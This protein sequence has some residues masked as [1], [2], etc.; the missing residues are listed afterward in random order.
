ML[1]RAACLAP[2][3]AFAPVDFPGRFRTSVVGGM[4]RVLRSQEGQ[5]KV[6]LQFVLLLLLASQSYLG[7]HD[8]LSLGNEAAVGT[9]AVLPLAEP[10][11]SFENG[12]DAVV[13]TTSALGRTKRVRS[14]RAFCR[15][16]LTG[17]VLF[18]DHCGTLCN[19]LRNERPVL[20]I[21][22]NCRYNPSWRFGANL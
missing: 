4:R 21:Y 19:V 13:P 10:F 11:V 6:L 1:R 17:S 14:G 7:S 9:S 2:V 16:V 15:R 3:T 22:I 5:I 8:P 18:H 20:C 12:N